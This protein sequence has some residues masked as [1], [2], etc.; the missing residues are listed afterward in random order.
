MPF[1]N[2]LRLRYRRVKDGEGEGDKRSEGQ[3]T[4]KKCVTPGSKRFKIRHTLR[5]MM[6]RGGQR[7]ARKNRPRQ[8]HQQTLEA[9]SRKG[10]KEKRKFFQDVA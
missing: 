10:K 4:K 1:Q 2:K 7:D 6:K 9:R 3:A 5:S 8:Y